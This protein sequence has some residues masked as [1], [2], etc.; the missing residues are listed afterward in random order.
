MV[1]MSER[2]ADVNEADRTVLEHLA[3]RLEVIAAA[4]LPAHN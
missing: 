1:L 4:M 3:E 2:L